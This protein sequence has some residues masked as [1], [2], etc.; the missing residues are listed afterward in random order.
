MTKKG[1]PGPDTWETEITDHTY[2][3]T[4]PHGQTHSGG[5][6]SSMRIYKRR[7]PV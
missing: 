5:S 1:L 6:N 7:G 3:R 4:A 2:G